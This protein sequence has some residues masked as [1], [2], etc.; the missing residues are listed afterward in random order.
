MQLFAFAELTQVF[1]SSNLVTGFHT[2]LE[3]SRKYLFGSMGVYGKANDSKIVGVYMIRGNDIESI[4]SVAPDYESYEFTPLDF[5]ADQEF[6]AGSWS[7]EHTVEY[8]FSPPLSFLPLALPVSHPL[9]LAS[10]LFLSPSLLTLPLL[11]PAA[12]RSTP[13]ARSSSE[14]FSSVLLLCR[15]VGAG[16]KSRRMRRERRARVR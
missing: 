14:R 7:W 3:A 1:M 11:R 2:R 8:V 15:S 9:F 12:V 6:I 10:S 16:R 4:F 5:N 13:T